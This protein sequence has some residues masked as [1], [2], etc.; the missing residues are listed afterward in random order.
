MI[1]QNI[2][3]H[4]LISLYFTFCYSSIPHAESASWN[5]IQNDNIHIFSGL[6]EH[7]GSFQGNP[8]EIEI[9]ATSADT[10]EK[11]L[12]FMYSYYI[13]CLRR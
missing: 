5:V 1:V 13:I 10:M 7:E 6:L 11:I 2:M 9:P 4:L 12:F 3:K 8:G